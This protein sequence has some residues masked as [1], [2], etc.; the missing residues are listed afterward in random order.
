MFESSFV[1]KIQPLTLFK[2]KGEASHSGRAESG[3]QIRTVAKCKA[4]DIPTISPR[5]VK[6]NC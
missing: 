4:F 3:W 2:G 5:T 6:L 1:A